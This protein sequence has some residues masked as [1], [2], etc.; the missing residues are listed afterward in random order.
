[1]KTIKIGLDARFALGER[2]GIG[3]FSLDLFRAMASVPHP[4]ELVFYSDREDQE[5]L[6]SG[7]PNARVRVLG[8][9]LYPVWEQL[10]LPRAL[11]QDGIRLFHG[12]GN[13]GPVFLPGNIKRVLTIHDVMFLKPVSELPRSPSM[14]QRMG[15]IYRRIIAP[16]AGRRADL[17]FTDSE[18][19]RQDILAS[20]PGL[21][22]A[23]V[24][25]AYAG[26]P[27]HFLQ[28]VRTEVAHPL[29]GRPYLLHL[30]ALDP[31]K[32][33]A[34]VVKCYLSLRRANAIQEQLVILGLKDLSALG[35]S[36]AESQEAQAWLHF[37]GYVPAQDIPAYYRHAKA[38]LFPSLYEGFGIPLLEAMAC[39]TPI[40]TS[41]TTSLPEI[42][43]DAALLI[44]PKDGEALKK[45][46]LD[47]L[48]DS[49]LGTALVAKG[50]GRIRD[51]TWNH[52]AEQVLRSYG[53]LLGTNGNVGAR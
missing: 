36:P 18:F 49:S 37:P 26:L 42:A 38:F 25:V 10:A 24:E 39:G 4:F 53:R 23:K 32:N 27:G 40:I 6:L 17:T 52:T 48:G 19:S 41:N 44:D 16:R 2:R 51:F 9:G 7:L 13:T 14:Y 30:G 11:G 15:R 45:T 28:A 31:R 1:L 22:P 43:G 21:D 50:T 12:I 29:E 8:P 20:I 46:I 5:G 47:L 3:N 35:L 33:T 34:L